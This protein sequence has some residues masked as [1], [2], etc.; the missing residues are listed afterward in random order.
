MLLIDILFFRWRVTYPQK[1]FKAIRRA[2]IRIQSLLRMGASKRAYWAKKKEIEEETAIAARMTVIQQTFDDAS[3]VQG[4]VFSIDEGLLDEVETMFEFLR[5][6]IVVLRKKNA[7]L[8]RQ[9][10]ESEAFK[11]EIYNHASSVDHSFALAK[12]R[13]EQMTKT[14][15]AL[16][17]DNNRRRKDNSKLKNE[18]ALQQQSHGEQ[19]NQ[20]RSDFD[21]A[22]AN[23]EIEVKN[24]QASYLSAA[25]MHKRE[26]QLIREESER[27]QEE[28]FSEIDR[29]RD[30]IKMTQVM[31][32]ELLFAL[33][34]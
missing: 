2:S 32:L 17:E 5:K 13:I 28:H 8:K 15:S 21:I 11:R 4:T 33:T 9:L 20:M 22:L 29:L 34:L 7:T 1:Q 14:N 16:L 19:L 6:E 30:E 3:T 31:Y 23:R 24:L 26:V 27:K 10:T 18:L 25:A 12:I